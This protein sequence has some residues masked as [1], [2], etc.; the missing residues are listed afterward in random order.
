M[1]SLCERAVQQRDAQK[2][3]RLGYRSV[4]AVSTREMGVP[5]YRAGSMQQRIILYESPGRALPACRAQG[6][7]GARRCTRCNHRGRLSG[8]YH[9]PVDRCFSILDR[10]EDKVQAEGAGLRDKQQRACQR[11]KPLRVTAAR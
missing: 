8:S 6:R 1:I 2:V 4:G 11:R 3:T 5:V 7:V 10:D 9:Y